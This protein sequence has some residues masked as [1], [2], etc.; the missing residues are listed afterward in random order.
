MAFQQYPQKGGI[1][2]GATAARPSSPA[3]G[4]TYYN[5]TLTI[6]EI[7]DGSA[8]VACSAPPATPS[9]AS[10]TDSGTSN[11][12]TS[13]GS[14]TVVVNPG[15]GGGT[16]S[17]YNAFTTVGGFTGYSATTTIVIDG[18]T[19]GTSYTAY[20]NAQN[21]FG[22]SVNTPNAGAVTATTKP[23]APTIG[24][25]TAGTGAS[26]NVAWTLGATGGK[27]LTSISVIP[28]LNGTTAQTARTAATTSDTSL[29][30][31]G[32]TAGANYTFKVKTTNA[33]GDSP[34][35]S[36]S[37]SVTVP[38]TITNL[39]I[40]VIAGGGAGAAGNPGNGGAG[41]GAG[42]YRL[43]TAQTL[44]I[45]TT[46]TCTV[47]AGAGATSTATAHGANGNN[48]SF[49]GTAFTTIN[50]TAGGGG[51][52]N[53]AVNRTGNNGG[54]G[55]GGGATSANASPGGSGNAGGYS[56]VEGYAGGT[57]ASDGAIY[58]A[59]GGGGGAGAVGATATSANGGT[60]GAGGIG[61]TNSTLNAIGAATTTGQLSGGN[62]YYAGG[63][64]AGGNNKAASAGGLGGGGAGGDGATTTT[65]SAGRNA[66]AN[67]GGGGGGANG[68]SS[69]TTG[70]AGGSGII[71]L[72]IPGTFT[73][74]STTGSP[75]RVV[76]SSFT[77][78]TFT[79]D[80]S[81]TI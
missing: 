30:V 34:E 18:L 27:A 36:A 80:G 3:I 52:S 10:V 62:Y 20:A 26:V 78:Y 60:P 64:G 43:F 51:G 45:G 12:Y 13:G 2:S 55:G 9:I 63:G 76:A 72:R 69:T 47:G 7:W 59:G 4:D 38:S 35:S 29:I 79:G 1:P 73:A 16:P 67:T 48:S 56:P 28:Y 31:T 14:F 15:S 22:T 23:Q 74:S 70:G 71:V 33:N 68:S 25:A 6:L 54:S 57:G 40:M 44:N 81:I 8:W 50:A 37:N 66:T 75:T 41:G 53:A 11:A 42:G 24:T 5:G 77:Y 39:D 21:N 49:S 32:L 65:T 58:D 17:Q 46:Y 19:P 61:A